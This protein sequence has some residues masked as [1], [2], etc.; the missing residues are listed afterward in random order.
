MVFSVLSVGIGVG[1]FVCVNG[2]FSVFSLNSILSV[3]SANSFF[4]ILSTNSFASIL[5]NN[6]FLCIGCGDGGFM[7]FNSGWDFKGSN[8]QGLT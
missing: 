5:S 6:C 2:I 3:L 7:C 4:S 1:S 8:I